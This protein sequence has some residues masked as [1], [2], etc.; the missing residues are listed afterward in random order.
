MKIQSIKFEKSV[1]HISQLPKLKLPE[2]AFAGRSNVGKSSL[3]NCLLNRKHLAKISSTPGKTRLLNFF[4]INESFYFVDLP[5]YGFARVP[6]VEKEKWQELVESYFKESQMLRGVIIIT[7]IRHPL[8]KLDLEMI[9][10]IKQLNIPPLFI[11]TKADKL[12]GNKL[13]LQFDENYQQLQQV[14]PMAEL[15]PFSAETHAGRKEVWQKI[16]NMLRA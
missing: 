10:W 8:T 14:D 15:L 4:L 6:P 9:N 3:I 1:A 16:T 5:G 7:D 2:I 12:S 11:G 13:T